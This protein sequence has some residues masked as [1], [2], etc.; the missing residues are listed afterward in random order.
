MTKHVIFALLCLASCEAHIVEIPDE[1][2]SCRER[3][4]YNL[5]H[6]SPAIGVAAYHGCAQRVLV[7][8]EE[9]LAVRKDEVAKSLEQRG[10]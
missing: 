4:D 6:C 7:E 2:S 1:N 10:K 5:S 9:C 3:H 8:F